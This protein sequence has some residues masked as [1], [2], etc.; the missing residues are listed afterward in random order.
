MCF[1]WKLALNFNFNLKL[2]TACGRTEELIG[3][4]LGLPQGL[5]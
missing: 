4:C 3:M 1:F 2:M 5:R